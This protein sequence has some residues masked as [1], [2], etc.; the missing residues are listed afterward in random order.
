MMLDSE[1]IN[2]ID[3]GSVADETEQADIFKKGIY[4]RMV[5]IK[6]FVLLLL[7]PH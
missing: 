1:I 3:E 5:K 2:L 7:L 4:F 6:S